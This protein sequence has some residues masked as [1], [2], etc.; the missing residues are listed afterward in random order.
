[1]KKGHSLGSSRTHQYSWYQRCPP[2]PLA[3]ATAS[4]ER[5]LAV[6]M[7]NGTPTLAAALA[8]ASSPSL[9]KMPCTP[10]GAMSIGEGNLTP[11]RVVCEA[12]LAALFKLLAGW[13]G[14]GYVEITMC[15]I[16]KHTGYN[17]PLLQRLQITAKCAPSSGV[18]KRIHIGS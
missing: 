11:K 16:A 18:A 13:S 8:V 5:A 9:C 12:Q 2:S 4:M 17:A 6:D 1:M 15:S 14:G 3:L 7:M 10:T